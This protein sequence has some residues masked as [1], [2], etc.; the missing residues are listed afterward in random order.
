MV[1]RTWVAAVVLVLVVATAITIKLLVR[2]RAPEGGWF[3][4]SPRSAGTLSVIGTMFAVVLAF[5]IFLALQG[6]QRARQAS[7]EE[8]VA[9]TEL[10]SVAAAF[11]PTTRDHLQGGLVCYARAVIGDEWSAMSVGRSSERV[12]GWS[13]KLSGEI[14]TIEP[15]GA[16]EQEAYAQWFDLQ[17]QRREGR[18]GRLA[19]ATPLVPDPLWFVLGIGAAIT[20]A[21]MCAQ[22]DRREGL[23]VQSIPIGFV[24]TMVTAGMLVIFFLDHPF[25]NESGGIAPT[26]MRQ[27]LMTIDHGTT[28]PCDERGSGRPT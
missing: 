8:A 24:S 6:Y 12:Q 19:V 14:A 18:R 17:A 27:T 11:E 26:E 2:R 4:D 21:Y 1:V 9:I 20:I 10:H 22:A 23:L 5:V 15:H 16:R 3:K 7:T 28:P 25:A 13:D